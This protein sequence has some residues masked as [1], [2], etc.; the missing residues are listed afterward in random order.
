MGYPVYD[1]RQSDGE[2]LVI[3]EL[4]HRSK[5][6]TEEILSLGQIEL[7]DIKIELFEREL[8]DHLTMCR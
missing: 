4:C 6:A 7:F 1:I 5:E 8:F 3:L 2:A